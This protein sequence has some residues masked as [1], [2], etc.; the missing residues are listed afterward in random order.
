MSVASIKLVDIPAFIPR[1]RFTFAFNFYVRGHHSAGASSLIARFANN[2]TPDFTAQPKKHKHAKLGRNIVKITFSNDLP[3]CVAAF[4][5]FDVTSENSFAQVQTLINFE[6]SYKGIK[7]PVGN[8]SDLPNRAIL[9]ERA[10]FYAQDLGVQYF[11]VCSREQR[12]VNF[13]FESIAE[14][15][16]LS[17]ASGATRSQRIVQVGDYP[18]IRY[19]LCEKL[20]RVAN[21][22]TKFFI[23]IIVQTL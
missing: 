14:S 9:Y 5:V 6:R 20:K 23:D 22:P 1:N 19:N 11:E 21:N 2:S 12:G 15:V 4:F 18:I 8:K 16:F 3:T 17:L 13:I 7:V 10:L